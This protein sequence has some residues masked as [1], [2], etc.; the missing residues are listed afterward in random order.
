VS[1]AG[2]FLAVLLFAAA[3]CGDEA[4]TPQVE[5]RDEPPRADDPPVDD[6][7]P[8]PAPVPAPGS[9]PPPTVDLPPFDPT[10]YPG[11]DLDVETILRHMR[12]ARPTKFKPVGSTSVVFKVDLDA[13]MSM[14]W[15]PR[16]KLHA[17]GWLNEIAAWRLSR[18]LGMD[19]VPPAI[20]RRFHK[21]LM[22][23]RFDPEFRDG[24]SDYDWAMPGDR[25][26]VEGVC[27]FWVDGMRE[28]GF[29]S[30][31]GRARWENGLSQS[32][33]LPTT[34]TEQSLMRDVSTMI[35][36]DYVIAN[37]DRWSGG[38][39]RADRTGRRVVIR[40]HNLAFIRPVPDR[41][42]QRMLTDLR[43]VERF[44][45]SFITRLAALDEPT[46]RAELTQDPASRTDPALDSD[47]LHDTLDRAQTVL[48]HVATLIEQHGE[49]R[50]LV[51]P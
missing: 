45:R 28:L 22:R 16:T 18:A 5:L 3:S 51:F 50:V 6:P 21:P 19:S 2:A 47:Q 9:S 34:P 27:V 32:S 44:S 46:L 11:T 37:F 49:A 38:N 26:G 10:R 12:E 42:A 30:G 20:T 1:R 33:P 15:R 13:P 8:D 40:D 48:S 41:L 29:E 35:A 31:S 4:A 7:S 43:K 39:V 36:F 17:R 14:A 25:E 23:D 24:W